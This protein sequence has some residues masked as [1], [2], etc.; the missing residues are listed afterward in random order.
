M[1]VELAIATRSCAEAR[2]YQEGDVRC[3]KQHPANWGPRARRETLIIIVDGMTLDEARELV[4]GWW[5]PTGEVFEPLYWPNGEMMVPATPVTER[6]AKHRFNIPLKVLRQGWMPGLD[7]D[8]ARDK[9]DPYQPFWP[10]GAVIDAREKVSLCWDKK[11]G[12]AKYTSEKV[13]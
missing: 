13:A 6:R 4:E 5:E 3:A 9:T 12:K 10:F 11:T 7:L 8:R 1:A 2:R